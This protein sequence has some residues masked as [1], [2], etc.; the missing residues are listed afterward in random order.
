MREEGLGFEGEGG[1]KYK[2]ARKKD[3]ER[4]KSQSA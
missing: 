4:E 2:E 1:K 3:R